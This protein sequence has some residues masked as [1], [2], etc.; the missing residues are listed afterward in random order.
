[1]LNHKI[2]VYIP[3]TV[4]GNQPA[5]ADLIQKWERQAKIT[6]ASLFGGFTAYHGQGGWFSPEHGLIEENV[7]IVQAF[8]DEAGLANVGKVRE[9]AQ[10]IASAMEQEVVSVEVDGQL[11][12]IAPPAD[13]ITIGQPEALSEVA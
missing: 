8:T 11:N 10:E 1:M 13:T 2:A 9:L 4:K 3:S 7:T 5:P 12:F 6:L